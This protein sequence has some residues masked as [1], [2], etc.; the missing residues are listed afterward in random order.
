MAADDLFQK[1]PANEKGSQLAPGRR[2]FFMCKRLYGQ[3][4]E[5][6]DAQEAAAVTRHSKGSQ[7]AAS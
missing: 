4:A 7:W 5:A 3:T 1:I 2:A 6:L